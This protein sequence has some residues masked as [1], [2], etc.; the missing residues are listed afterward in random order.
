MKYFFTICFLI[1]GYL[2]AAQPT[3][4]EIDAMMKKIKD[5]E[6][7]G[8]SIRKKYPPGSGGTTIPTTP[9]GGGGGSSSG[10]GLDKRNLPV[11]DVA[12][13]NIIPK[14]DLSVAELRTYLIAF[15]AQLKKKMP[16]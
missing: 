5:I 10:G 1:T 14:K 2:L 9:T 7:Q 8:D 16:A 6:K 12:R 11:K 13:I 15:Q 3:Q 4:A